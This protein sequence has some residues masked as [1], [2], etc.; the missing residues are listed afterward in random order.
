MRILFGHQIFA[1]QQWGGVSRYFV[2]LARALSRG[3]QPEIHA[4]LYVSAALENCRELCGSGLQ[5][6]AVQGAT[7]VSNLAARMIRPRGRYDVVHPTWY[8][9]PDY[10]RLGDKLV[11]TIHD[12]IAELLPATLPSGVA[13]HQSRLKRAA[14]TSADVLICVSENTKR[15]LV[16]LWGVDA[17][18]V[19]VT[20]LASSI[21][22]DA[23]GRSPLDVPYLLYVG[24]RDGY[25]NF[26]VLLQA[27]KASS[28]LS[29]EFALLCWGGGPFRPEERDELVAIPARGVGAV[30]QVSGDDKALAAT[31]SHA[32]LLACPSAYEGFGLP[33]LEAMTCGCP[34]L[35]T[36]AGSIPEVGA[37]AIAYVEESTSESWRTALEGL[38]EDSHRL[39][40]LSQLG[41]VRSQDFSW[42]A[43]AR[44][45]LQVYGVQPSRGDV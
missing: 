13:A 1:A 18:K 17:S 27:F 12:M 9:Q 41:Y 2:E 21:R 40:A 36:R 43:T 3:A 35:A 8:T 22:P 11:H 19:F 4:P 14:V 32:T 29:R 26:R 45:T 10:A 16:Q 34:V 6:P 38:L 44:A 42:E 28:K 5:L 25:K 39:Q 15:D 24:Q 31:Y 37:N 30:I 7:L 23:T 33:V 20:P